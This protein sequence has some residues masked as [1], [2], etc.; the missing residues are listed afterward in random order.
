MTA[1]EVLDWDLYGFQIYFIG[2]R[3]ICQWGIKKNGAIDVFKVIY[4]V[5]AENYYSKNALNQN[6]PNSPLIIVPNFLL[7]PPTSPG[8]NGEVDQGAPGLPV[9]GVTYVPEQV[10]DETQ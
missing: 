2:F 10:S 9:P 8:S 3:N 4:S 6:L 5:R 1:N 7:A